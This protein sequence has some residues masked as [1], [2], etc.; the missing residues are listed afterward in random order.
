MEK[1]PRGGRFIFLL[2][3]MLGWVGVKS[4]SPGGFVPVSGRYLLVL[5]PIFFSGEIF[6]FS[7]IFFPLPSPLRFVTVTEL[8]EQGSTVDRTNERESE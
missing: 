5:L 4:V 6:V 8:T 1:S 7:G 2:T 3:P